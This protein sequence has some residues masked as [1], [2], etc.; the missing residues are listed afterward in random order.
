MINMH[1]KIITCTIIIILQS[2]NNIMTVVHFGSLFINN[3]VIIL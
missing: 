1:L 3:Y 2:V